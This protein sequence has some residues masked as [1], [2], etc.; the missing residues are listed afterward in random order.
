MTQ[1]GQYEMAHQRF[2]YALKLAEKHDDKELISDANF[3]LAVL[4]FE[5]GEKGALV[6]A[7]RYAEKSLDIRRKLGNLE[8]IAESQTICADIYQRRGEPQRAEVA[9]NEAYQALSVA[10]YWYK[11][12]TCLCVMARSASSLGK[13]LPLDNTERG[14]EIVAKTCNPAQKFALLETRIQ[15]LMNTLQRQQVREDLEE[16]ETLTKTY[17]Y[18]PWITR[19][20]LLH[21]EFD[22]SRK[23]FKKTTKALKLFFDAASKLKNSYLTSLGYVLSAE[24]NFE[25]SKR[26]LSQISNEKTK[27][28][29]DKSTSI[30]ESLGAWHHVAET[31][32]KEAAF[33]DYLNETAEAEDARSRADK[34]DP[35][36]Q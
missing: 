34:V 10:G 26:N 28:L 13:P 27:R 18:L 19:Y 9:A 36:C 6:N 32:R 12:P 3:G 7:L 8:K 23:N 1:T 16:M 17:S 30:F 11:T 35:Y 21:A 4:H 5:S 24:L 2:L 31:L 20:Y 14:F 22:F 33:L 25:V 15:L 29:Y